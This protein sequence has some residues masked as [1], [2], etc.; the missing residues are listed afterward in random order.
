MDTSLLTPNPLL[1]WLEHSKPEA[2]LVLESSGGMVKAA[3]T[4]QLL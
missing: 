4:K 1:L 2:A 3:N